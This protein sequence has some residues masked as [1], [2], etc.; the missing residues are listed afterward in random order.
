M[1]Q[2]EA[3]YNGSWVCQSQNY[4]KTKGIFYG[5]NPLGHPKAVILVQ[6]SSAAL[7]TV[8]LRILFNPL[9][10]SGF[11]S[12]MI[13]GILLGPSI[14]GAQNALRNAI[15]PLRSV[16]VSQTFSYIGCMFFLFLVGV[17]TDLSII[18]KSGKKAVVI[19]FLTFILPLCLNLIMAALII[20]NSSKVH[21]DMVPSLEKSIYYIAACQALN[22]F[23]VVVCLLTD[24]K[25]L[26][27]EL[28]RLATSSSLVSGMCSWVT[29]ILFFTINTNAIRGSNKQDSL[30]YMYLSMGSLIILVVYILRPITL[31]MVKQMTEEKSVKEDH[32]FGV[33]LMVLSCG[34]FGEAIGQHMMLGPMMLGVAV[35][36]G[37]P[38]GSALVAKLESYVSV[39]LLPS[40]FVL[41]GSIV[42]VS[43]IRWKTVCVVESL[44]LSA[45]TGK[46]LATMLPAIYFKMPLG[47]ALCLGLIMTAQGITDVLMI[48]HAFSLKLISV[49]AYTVMSISM[50]LIT[51]ITT[52]IIK[53]LY[54]PSK[55]YVSHKV[56]RTI[57]HSRTN[58]ELRMMACIYTEDQTP[59]II[60][61]LELSNPT[62]RNPICFYIVHL[63]ELTGRSAPLLVTHHPG[64][65]QYSHYSEHIVNAFRLYEQQY[66]GI[67]V[68]NLFT[69]VSP[70]ATMHDEICSLAI[71][72]RVAMVIIPFHRQWA[73]HGAMDDQLPGRQVRSANC[74]IL[75]NAP[76][77]VGILVDRGTGTICSSSL[78]N[79]GVIFVQGPDDREAL[80][81]ALRM[82]D[83]P[84]VRLTLVRIIDTNNKATN[85]TTC[86]SDHLDDQII[87]EF[88][89]S[90]VGKKYHTYREEGVSDS[91]GTVGVIRSVENLFDLI[92]VGRRHD[93]DSPLF[94]GLTEWN[95]FPEL[96]F[97][98]DM[99]ASSDSNCH[100]SVLI[101][102]QQTFAN[103]LRGRDKFLSKDSSVILDMPRNTGKVWPVIS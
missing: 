56:R 93:N 71:D 63:L 10:E 47:D 36:D 55:R 79:I 37:P 28:G 92:L 100:V 18:K 16:Y 24:L 80:A 4:F 53:V 34:F 91:V 94:L 23:Y 30:L 25:L 84:N 90:M 7:F 66:R 6:L 96:G 46:L 83:H 2:I 59:S 5:G 54:N 75:H 89:I 57:Q 32:I 62:S 99:L 43:T 14:W 40:Y 12:Q 64:K 97:I 31:W 67:L 82:G 13:V 65:T 15:F 49:E 70:Y 21:D 69:A 72:K 78:C 8:I 50:V 35:P 76:C 3:A 52:P 58:A 29:A 68:V 98:G 22:S 42:N 45:F 51:G 101:V 60:N 86:Q 88:R 39:I 33:C 11:F 73:A 1:R 27:S 38:L 61:L 103:E 26:N 74:N 95:E 44:A 85:G 19:G 87:N 41:S 77:S 9:G 102:Q 20:K 81:Y 17:R 48:Q